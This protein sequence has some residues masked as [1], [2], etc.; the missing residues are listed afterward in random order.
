M[1]YRLNTIMNKYVNIFNI[2]NRDNCCSINISKVY[3][4]MFLFYLT[5]LIHNFDIRVTTNF[6]H[7]DFM[8][9]G[10]IWLLGFIYLY[11]LIYLPLCLVLFYIKILLL[12]N[13]P[14]N[15]FCNQS[16]F[17]QRRKCFPMIDSSQI[18]TVP[19]QSIAYPFE[20]YIINVKTI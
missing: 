13:M 16:N 9:V 12:F 10:G 1:K 8:G 2:Y 4:K 18:Y 11:F 17:K 14:Y 19:I 15:F 7:G 20:N 5:K 6:N 3:L